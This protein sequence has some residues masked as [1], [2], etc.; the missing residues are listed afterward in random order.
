MRLVVVFCLCDHTTMPR[1]SLIVGVIFLSLFCFKVDT[2]LAAEQE[3]VIISPTYQEIELDKNVD[4][5]IG[6]FS[7]ENATDQ[8]LQFQFSAVAYTVTDFL[9]SLAFFNPT[10]NEAVGEINYVQFD[11]LYAN[12]PARQSQEITFRVRNRPTLSPGGHYVALVGKV[13]THS[14][15]KQ[16]VLPA[17]SSLLLIKKVDGEQMNLSLVSVQDH[18]GSLAMRL[19]KRVELSLENQGNVHVLPRGEVKIKDQFGRVVSQGTINEDS[20]FVLPGMR[21]VIT[22]QMRQSR[23]VF[24][25]SFLS[26]TVDGNIVQS[27]LKFSYQSSFFFI[28]IKLFVILIVGSLLGLIVWK[29]RHKQQHRQR[30]RIRRKLR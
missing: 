27:A 22:V 9:G 21:R 8:D 25:I 7:I 6:V 16:V 24:P 12:I 10:L 2:V 3:S 11:Q 30:T 19:P 14:Q 26:L 28:S 18:V 13:V 29:I 23:F 4:E 5:Q 17:I 1:I 20:V 15:E